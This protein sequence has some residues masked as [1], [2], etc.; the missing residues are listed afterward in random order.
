M[1]QLANISSE[2]HVLLVDKT[3]GLLAGALIEKHAK[4]ILSVEL[5]TQA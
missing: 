5:A 3:R 1:L 4:E 2:S